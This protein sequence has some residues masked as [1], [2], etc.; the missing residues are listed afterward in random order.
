VTKPNKWAVKQTQVLWEDLS[1]WIEQLY[2]EFHAR[3]DIS[4]S[5]LPEAWKLTSAVSVVVFVQGLGKERR[6]LWECWKPL[7]KRV[8][9]A[10]ES[11]VLQMI[12]QALLELSADRD[13][14][15]RAQASFLGA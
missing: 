6:V 12:S 1:P 9:G 14:A 11:V 7:Q 2:E 10:A 15:E 8:G 3:V 13:S 4:V 5:C